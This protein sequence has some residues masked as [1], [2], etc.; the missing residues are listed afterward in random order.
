V[1]VL[2]EIL[3]L[4]A[5]CFRLGDD[6]WNS[7]FNV[8]LPV[9]FGKPGGHS[10]LGGYFRSCATGQ[11]ACGAANEASAILPS[12]QAFCE[13]VAGVCDARRLGVIGMCLTGSFPLWLMRSELVHAPVLCQPSIPFSLVGAGDATALGLS[14]RDLRLA[15]ARGDV[16]ILGMRYT[17]D[18]RCPMQRFTR[19]SELF[20]ARFRAFEI[21]SGVGGAPDGHSVLVGDRW[22]AAYDRTVAFL[23]ERLRQGVPRR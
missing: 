18:W 3:G 7:G 8:F 20:G 13:H 1:V 16:P 9:L 6:L 14:A 2:H 15:I 21:P 10:F 12:L 4:S 11:F 23:E 17:N 19:L 5:A 22:P